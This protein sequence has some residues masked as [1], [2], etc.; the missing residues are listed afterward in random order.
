MVLD[1][2]NNN[3]QIDFN[4]EKTEEITILDRS[5]KNWTTE[6]NLVSNNAHKSVIDLRQWSPERKMGKGLTL[7][8]QTAKNLLLALESYFGDEPTQE[9]VAE[10]GF[11][12]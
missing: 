8:E 10:D 12:Y 1:L 9:T 3:T 6:L 2:T 11:N 5:R 7:T 4:F